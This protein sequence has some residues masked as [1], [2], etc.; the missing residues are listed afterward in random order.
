[1][2]LQVGLSLAMNVGIVIGY[3]I[4][5]SPVHSM[6]LV[7]LYMQSRMLLFKL[8]KTVAKTLLCIFGGMNLFVFYVKGLLSKQGLKMFI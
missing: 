7:V 8:G 4:I 1:M 3:R 2:V 5:F 6:K